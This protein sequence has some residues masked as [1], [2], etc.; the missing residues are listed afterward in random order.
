M[1]TI[2]L[3]NTE[4]I[5]CCNAIVDSAD[6]GVTQANPVLRIYSGSVPGL[7]DDAL[8]AQV[9]LAELNMTNPAFGAAVDIA[10]GARATANAI[11]DD[12]SANAT[13]TASFF[14]IFDRQAT[15]KA[16]IQG[17]VSATG[18]GGVLELNSTAIQSGAI[19][20]V[21]SLTITVLEA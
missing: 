5:T 7:V 16:V 18:G 15:A 1:A 19:V 3:S 17:S 11:S 13:G 9:I 8:G 2:S 4:A 6:V 12:T 20:R 10:P 14:R 21:T